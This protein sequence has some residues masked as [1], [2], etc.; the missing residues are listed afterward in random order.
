VKKK[1][2]GFTR[3]HLAL[4]DPAWSFVRARFK[5][6]HMW[7]RFTK[8][9]TKT[10]LAPSMKLLMELKLKNNGFTGEVEPCQTGP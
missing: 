6:L 1:N 4:V 3:L 9:C 5:K 2:S 10:A 8:R 7:S